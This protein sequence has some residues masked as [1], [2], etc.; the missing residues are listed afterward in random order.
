MSDVRIQERL[1]EKQLTILNGELAR[2]Q[3][4]VGMGY[5]LLILLGSFGVHKFYLGKWGFGIIYAILNILGWLT[6]PIGVGLIFFFVLGIFLIWDLFT[7]GNQIK[8]RE[9]KIKAEIIS[10]FQ[11][12]S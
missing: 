4:S 8:K 3:R 11:T 6:L 12:Q 2:E 9:E 7:L 1:T 10:T 5:I